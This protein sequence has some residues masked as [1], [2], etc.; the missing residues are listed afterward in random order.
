MTQH[1]LE[2]N[3]SNYKKS[4]W[5]SSG[6]RLGGKSWAAGVQIG[7]IGSSDLLLRVRQHSSQSLARRQRVKCSCPPDASH[8]VYYP[9][10]FP[11]RRA[12][13]Q[14][15]AKTTLRVSV[16]YPLQMN[17]AEMVQNDLNTHIHTHEGLFSFFFFF[18][19]GPKPSVSHS[20]IMVCLALPL[21]VLFTQTYSG[22][23]S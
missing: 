9:S 7:V 8:S 10:V 17:V 13:I 18:F 23:V 15:I 20:R 14:F 5:H 2:S 19:Q 16:H 6:D 11:N 3:R 1:F 4:E 21:P 22:R 12:K